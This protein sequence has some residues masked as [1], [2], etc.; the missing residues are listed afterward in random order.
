ALA[1]FIGESESPEL[2]EQAYREMAYRYPD[3]A[4]KSPS[5]S[6]E[7]VLL[8]AAV[9]RELRVSGCYLLAERALRNAVTEDCASRTSATS[10]QPL[11][12]RLAGTV[13]FNR[14]DFGEATRSLEQASNRINHI[15]DPGMHLRLG[16]S[17]QKTGDAALACSVGK[18]LYQDAPLFPGVEALLKS[19]AYR[20]GVAALKSEIQAIRRQ[21]VL[22]GEHPSPAKVPTLSLETEKFE[23]LETTLASDGRVT[24]AVFFAT[25]CPHCQRE[26]PKLVEFQ[27]TIETD[28]TLKGKV[29]VVAVRTLIER[30]TEQYAAFKKRFGINFPVYT[31]PAMGTA[32]ASFAR[33]QGID[34]PGVPLVALIDDEADVRYI[35]QS[36]EYSDTIRELRWLLDAIRG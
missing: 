11:E 6:V 36:H 28:P 10:D 13:A 16:A 12:A 24:V 33:S 23:P 14:G 4:E 9:D 20:K 21:R 1:G 26:L 17:A 31:D 18:K 5:K 29:R 25:W 27:R 15:S 2:R 8:N 35:L 32:L 34:Q 22:N 19:C 7:S 3:V 30:E